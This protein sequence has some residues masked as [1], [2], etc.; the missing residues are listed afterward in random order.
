MEVTMEYINTLLD[1]VMATARQNRENIGYD[2]EFMPVA[3]VVGPEGQQAVLPMNHRS[4]AEKRA[5][6]DALAQAAEE[7]GVVAIAVTS[8]VRWSDSDKFTSYFHMAPV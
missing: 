6:F 1:H 3:V 2:G 4:N 5:K 8:D 7:M